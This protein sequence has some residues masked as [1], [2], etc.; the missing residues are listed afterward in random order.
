MGSERVRAGECGAGEWGGAVYGDLRVVKELVYDPCG[1]V[2]SE[3]VAEAESAEYAAHTFRLDGL[4]VRYR[5]ARTTPTK[6]GQFVTVWKREAGGPIQP[7]D[8]SDSVDLFVI[9]S[10]DGEHFGQFVFPPDVLRRHGVVA[11]GG[12]GGKRGFRVY[13]PWVATTNR[14]AAAAQA[15]QV[16]CFLEVGGEGAGVDLERA[17]RLYR[18]P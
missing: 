5:A 6:V 11:E 3:P 2:C 8:V 18:R 1:F 16:E 14:T 4:A 12:R 15:W 10:R 17:V 9:G 13:P 7:F